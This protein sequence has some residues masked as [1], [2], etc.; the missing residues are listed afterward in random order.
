MFVPYIHRVDEFEDWIFSDHFS[1]GFY[2]EVHRFFEFREW[3]RVSFEH[4]EVVDGCG[5]FQ[6][7]VS[8][9]FSDLYVPFLG[10][11]VSEGYVEELPKYAGFWTVFINFS[12]IYGHCVLSSFEC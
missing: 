6:V 10:H 12:L 11:Y 1:G 4:S 7:E 5:N 3:G 8:S 2:S 9:S